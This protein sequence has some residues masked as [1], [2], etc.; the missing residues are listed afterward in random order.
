MNY[1]NLIKDIDQR[2][3]NNIILLNISESYLYDMAIDIIKEELLDRSFLDLNFLKYDFESLDK[4]IFTSAVETMPF[5]DQKRFILIE[6]L[7]LEK[8]K[9]K[10]YEEK[11]EFIMDYMDDINPS[12]FLILTY[13]GSSIFKGKFINKLIK[14]GQVYDISRLDRKEFL[15]FIGK[16]FA[17]NK[18]KIGKNQATFIADRLAYTDRDSKLTLY[19][20]VNELQKLVNSIDTNEPDMKVI[21]DVVT[22]HFDDNIFKLTDALCNRDIRLALELYSR[23]KDEYPNRIFA[24]ILRQVRILIGVKSLM[25]NK[26][27]KASGMK[28]LKIGSFEYDKGLRFIKN[29]TKKEILSI[30]KKAAELEMASRRGLDIEDAV[31]RLI[32]EFRR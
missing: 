19:E 21:E 31:K 25:E 24:M 30:H 11:F 27:S 8:D 9:I 22:E 6:N 28:Y 13:Q 4:N 18:I 26:V 12:T 17:K 1:V 16:Y 2:K 14:K 32:L 20:V 7:A 29:F 5:M 15:S 10:K 23:M 3:L